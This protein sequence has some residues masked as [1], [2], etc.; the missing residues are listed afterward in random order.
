MRNALEF[1]KHG[2]LHECVKDEEYL[3][4]E[5]EGTSIEGNGG[6]ISKKEYDP[7]STVHIA[8]SYGSSSDRVAGRLLTTADAA[9]AIAP[10]CRSTVAPVSPSS[11]CSSNFLLSPKPTVQSRLHHALLRFAASVAE[12]VKTQQVQ[13]SIVVS[14]GGTQQ[15]QFL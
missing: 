5:A 9:P 7:L 14:L 2:G 11:S 10:V 4:Q 1:E 3:G 13:V 8:S 15:S 6:R 12:P